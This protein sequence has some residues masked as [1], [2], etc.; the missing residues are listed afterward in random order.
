MSNEFSRGWVKALVCGC[1][2]GL[3]DADMV[4][5]WFLS[6]ETFFLPLRQ[7]RA[8][9][10]F[11]QIIHSRK[12]SFKRPRE[13][14]VEAKVI[15]IK[16]AFYKQKNSFSSLVFVIVKI[17][18]FPS[19][20]RLRNKPEALLF[21]LELFPRFPRDAYEKAII[22][23]LSHFAISSLPKSPPLHHLLLDIF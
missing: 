11:T 17:F 16:E 18:S 3:K 1:F 6:I 19:P 20:L 23:G 14:S 2:E 5:K 22:Y 15:N 9:Q 8:S 12:L 7:H 4:V 10:A 21:K 13:D